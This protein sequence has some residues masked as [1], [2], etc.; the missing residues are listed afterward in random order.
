MKPE[1]HATVKSA[2]RAFDI[3][4]YVADAPE[5]PSFS[6]LLADLA[7]PRSSLFHLLNN[8]QA[9]GY[10]AQ[11]PAS[12][13]YRLGDRIRQLAGRISG[14]PLAA[15]VQPLLTQLSGV[16]NETSAFYLRVG[17]AMETIASAVGRQAL[18]YTMKSGERAPLY[19]ISG[20]KILLAA[21]APV[22]LVAYLER[23]SLDEITPNTI[24]SK[25]RLREDIAAAQRDGFAYSREEFTPGITGIATAVLRH[26]QVFG[27]LNLAV[28]TARFSQSQDGVFRRQLQSTA[29]ALTRALEAGTAL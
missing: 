13:R 6:K 14:P 1:A 17:D 24:R 22:D 19:A 11:D 4:E 21:M 7:I 29:A 15:I 3:L 23:V 16:L 2:D 20:G 5:P 9:R 12:A 27:A 18:S 26:G 8:L 28:P 10:L 25:D